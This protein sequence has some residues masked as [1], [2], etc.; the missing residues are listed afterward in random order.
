MQPVYVMNNKAEQATPA[1]V[2]VDTCEVMCIV[3]ACTAVHSVYARCEQQHCNAAPQCY[4][5][6]LFAVEQRT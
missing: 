1:Y 5:V 2:C 6:L 4:R 3:T